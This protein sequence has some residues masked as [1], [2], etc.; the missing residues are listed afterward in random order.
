M[1]DD[2]TE[3]AE[4]LRIEDPQAKG[5][6][7]ALMNTIDNAL[8]DRNG[9]GYD[10]G[11]V[12]HLALAKGLDMEFGALRAIVVE[13]RDHTNGPRADLQW[14]AAILIRDRLTRIVRA[15]GGV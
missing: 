11:N 15:T 5:Q 6:A 8:T 10:N 7:T 1:R 12:E 2:F 4:L 13:L 9:V 3:C 14:E